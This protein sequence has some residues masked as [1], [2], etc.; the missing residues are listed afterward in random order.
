M[1]TSQVWAIGFFRDEEDIAEYVVKNMFA[2]GMDGVIV[3]LS[4]LIQ[5]NTRKILTRLAKECNLVLVND[6]SPSFYYY[7]GIETTKLANAAHAMR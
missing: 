4:H 2:Q 7:Q 5:D 3:A 6:D 1:A